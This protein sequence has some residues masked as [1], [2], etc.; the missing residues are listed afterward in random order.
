M[1]STNDA[2]VEPP[3][4]WVQVWF[5]LR[6]CNASAFGMGAEALSPDRVRLPRAPWFPLNATKGDIFRVQAGDENKLWVQDKIQ[7]SGYCAIKLMLADDSPLGPIDT[8]T[9]AMVD[10]FIPLAVTGL[11]M[12][13]VAVIDVP[14][15]A[16][17][18]RVRHLLDEGQHEGWWDYDELCVTDAWRTALTG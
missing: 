8:G 13:G 15:E 11:G 16:D 10:K 17:L 18:R 12:F 14:P 9:E 2:A 1:A 3:T 6:G 5:A 4:G 7:A